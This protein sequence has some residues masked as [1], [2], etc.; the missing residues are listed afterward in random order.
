M[1]AANAGIVD[2]TIRIVL[3]IMVLG[4]Y[5]ATEPPVQYFTLGGLLLIASGLSGFCPLY[6]L[7]GVSTCRRP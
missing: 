1:P 3:G 6:R 5:G 2:R 4:L 7:I